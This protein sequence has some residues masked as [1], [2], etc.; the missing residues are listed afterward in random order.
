VAVISRELA[1]RYWPRGGELGA[2]ITFE[3]PADPEAAWLTVVGVA[4]D[5][6]QEALGRPAYPQ[7]YLPLAQAPARSLV[8]AARTAGDPLALAPALRAVLKELDADLPLSEVS[9]MDQRVAQTLS[10]PRVNALL[11]GG[12][13]LTA[14]ALAAIGIYGVIAYGVVQRKRELGIRLALGAGR[15]NLLG[16]VVRQ[17]MRPVV[18]GVGLGIAAALAG[19]RLLRSLLFGVEP[20][21]PLTFALV[22]LFLL[23]V[24][25]AASWVPARRA[26]QSDPMVALRTD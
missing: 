14:L 17:G 18:A 19:T 4:G 16:L 12:F 23:T 15:D 21:D 2:R 5:V 24:A 22:G 9:T 10:R 6:R 8:I 20:G 13:A 11:L 7:V 26:A 1:R 25:L 3:D